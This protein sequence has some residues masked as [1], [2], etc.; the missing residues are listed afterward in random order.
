MSL[1]LTAQSAGALRSATELRR[2]VAVNWNAFGVRMVSY[3]RKS[4]S[5]CGIRLPQPEM[6]RRAVT[7]TSV[8]GHP[9]PSRL[10]WFCHHC[11]PPSFFDIQRA[12]REQ[13]RSDKD[14][15]IYNEKK[16]E[17]QAEQERRRLS[18]LAK[19]QESGRQENESAELY[20]QDSD[21]SIEDR[22]LNMRLSKRSLMMLSCVGLV[23]IAVAVIILV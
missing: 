21:Q 10:K 6:C 15:A 18:N 13:E 8:R 23:V 11:A 2:W 9:L 22:S 1:Q 4:C 20:E 17:W 14:A 16:R 12:K 19:R 5:S 7:P 3:S